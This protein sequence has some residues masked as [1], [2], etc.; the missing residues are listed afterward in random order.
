MNC[1]E[2]IFNEVLSC[3]ETLDKRTARIQPEVFDDNT[4]NEIATPQS[5]LVRTYQRPRHC[6]ASAKSCTCCRYFAHPD[7][8]WAYIVRISADL[9]SLSADRLNLS[10]ALSGLDLL[11]SQCPTGEKLTKFMFRQWFAVPVSLYGVTLILTQ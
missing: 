3:Y 2:M 8:S 5:T 1:A 10:G 4:P 7:Q 6:K 11:G 9:T